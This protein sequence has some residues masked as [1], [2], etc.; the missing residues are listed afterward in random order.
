MELLSALFVG[1]PLNT[2]AVALVFLAGHLL[3]RL[4]SLGFGTIGDCLRGPDGDAAI[5]SVWRGWRERGEHRRP[6]QHSAGAPLSVAG[7]P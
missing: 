2:L 6:P 4:T 7:P 1:R 3:L 5:G